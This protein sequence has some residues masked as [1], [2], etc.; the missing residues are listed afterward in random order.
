M[1]PINLYPVKLIGLLL[2]LAFLQSCLGEKLGT[3]SNDQINAGK[4][5]DFHNLNDQLL[6][7]LKTNNMDSLGYMMSKD[8]VED[9]RTGSSVQ[10]ISSYMNDCDYT[11]L[12]EYF[13]VKFPPAFDSLAN[14]KHGAKYLLQFQHTTPEMYVAIFLPKTGDNKYMLTAIY[15]KYSYGW[16]VSSLQTGKYTVNGLTSPQFYKLALQQYDKGYLVNAVN[17]MDLAERSSTPSDI[18]RY[19]QDSAMSAFYSK[20]TIEANDKYKFPF[21]LSQVPS[22]PKIARVVNQTVD[23]G[24]YPEIYYLSHIS[25]KD[26][27]AMR[28]EYEN[29]R[30]VIGQVMPGIDKENKYLLFAASNTLPNATKEVE[31]YRVVDRLR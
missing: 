21:E 19:E 7:G 25:L 4:R 11:L 2:L 18:W 31:Y 15:N 13:I 22:H 3:W 30:E 24:T 29:V 1:K 10:L 23:Q 16:K 26:T 9:G 14:S 27:T 6:R 12:D 20:I 17:F 8:M 28:Q 5:A